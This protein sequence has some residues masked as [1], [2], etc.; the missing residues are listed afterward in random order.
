LTY[1]LDGNEL[2][3]SRAN[4]FIL[5]ER[6]PKPTEQEDGWA[7]EQVWTLWSIYYLGK[8]TVIYQLIAVLVFYLGVS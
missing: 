5:G 4:R 6:S 8:N 7:P 1:A 3:A 2:S